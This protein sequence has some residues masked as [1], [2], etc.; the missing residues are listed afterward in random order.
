MNNIK[1]YK[2]ARFKKVLFRVFGILIMSILVIIA[3]SK[4]YNYVNRSEEV[5]QLEY[6]KEWVQERNLELDEFKDSPKLSEIDKMK[7]DQLQVLL[8]GMSSV[9][10]GPDKRNFVEQKIKSIINE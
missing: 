8:E 4:T 10:P 6:H 9:D 7:L 3:L 1:E 5:K 2:K